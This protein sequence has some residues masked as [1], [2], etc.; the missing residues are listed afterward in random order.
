MP[1]EAS[2]MHEQQWL[3]DIWKRQRSRWR[4]DEVVLNG[5]YLEMNTSTLGTMFICNMQMGRAS[6]LG[7]DAP[8]MQLSVRPDYW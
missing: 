2:S 7:Y 6:R 8:H 3:P 1:R 4:Y 5:Q